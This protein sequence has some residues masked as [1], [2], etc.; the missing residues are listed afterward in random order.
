MLSAFLRTHIVLS[1]PSWPHAPNTTPGQPPPFML[2]QLLLLQLIEV[3]F[4]GNVWGKTE[5][6]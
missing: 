5:P 1:P 3:K 4:S 2:A 6:S